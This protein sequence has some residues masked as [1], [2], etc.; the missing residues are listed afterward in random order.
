MEI[1]GKR[2]D[3]YSSSQVRDDISS[4][5]VVGAPH[6]SPCNLELMKSIQHLP[7]P[8]L[9]P[10]LDEMRSKLDA[11]PSCPHVLSLASESPRKFCEPCR[12][13][14]ASQIQEQDKSSGDESEDIP[15]ASG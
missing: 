9:T 11:V 6:L 4:S 13:P 10:H 15:L 7:S 5:T 2:D 3:K 8:P 14:D 12:I 1:Q